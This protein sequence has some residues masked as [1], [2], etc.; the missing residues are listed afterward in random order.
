VTILGESTAWPA[1]RRTRS[2]ALLL[3]LGGV[4]M[5]PTAYAGDDPP[6]QFPLSIDGSAF[7]N[8]GTAV[9]IDGDTAV[10]T[11]PL[12]NVDGNDGYG[13]A[14]VYLRDGA[15]WIQQARLSAGDP[16]AFSNYGRS[17]AIDGDTI[18][19]GASSADGVTDAAGAVY[20]Y[21]RSGA[22]WT[23]QAK[24]VADDGEGFSDF[25]IAVDVDGDSIV[26]GSPSLF[27]GG[28]N[29][30]GAAYVYVRNA[31]LWTQ[32]QKLVASDG[33]AFASFGNAVAID[34]D[35]VAVAAHQ[36]SVGAASFSGAVYAF[37]RSGAVWSQTQKLSP[38]DA[39]SEDAF[40]GSLAMHG[41][42]LIV[43]ARQPALGGEGGAGV[44]YVF[45]QSGG[46][47]TQQ[48]RLAADNGAQGDE[49]GTA[50]AIEGDR[51]VVSAP[52][53]GAVA[54]V[55]REVGTL[56][57]YARVATDWSQ[58]AR[59]RAAAGRQGDH[60]AARLGLSAGTA[61]AGVPEARVG[62]DPAQGKA[63]LFALDTPQVSVTPAALD[64][65]DVA[66][67]S[68][69]SRVLTLRNLGTAHLFAGAALVTGA[70]AAQFSIVDDDCS[71][72]RVEPAASCAVEVA[73]APSALTAFSA[74]VI[75]PGSAGTTFVAVSGRGVPPAPQIAIAPSAMAETVPQNETISRAITIG[76]PGASQTL[77][78]NLSEDPGT[79]SGRVRVLGDATPIRTVQP[80]DRVARSGFRAAEG[81]RVVRPEGLPPVGRS[82]THSASDTIA[83]GN[84]IA[85]AD[86][87]TGFTNANQFLRT[88]TLSDFGID[89]SFAVTS[90]NVG[91]ERL[92]IAMPL[93]LNLYAL[94]GDLSYFNMQRLASTSVIL[95]PLQTS[96]VTLPI[97]LD[98]PPGT[99][100]VVEIA[101]PSL[102]AL[103]GVFIPGSNAAGQSAPSYAAAAACNADDPTDLADIGFPGMHL[104]MSVTGSSD[105]PPVDCALPAWLEVS[106]HA[107]AVVPGDVQPLS[108][109]FDATGLAIGEYTANLCVASNAQDSLV[110]VPVTLAVTAG[111]EL[112]APIFSDGF[113]VALH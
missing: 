39:A 57:V 7:E 15:N 40:G 95:Q 43:G 53:N 9:A 19:V 56:Y 38:A 66:V 35:E 108:V 16:E 22:N 11:T 23:Q 45:V 58:T 69:A 2:L 102:D 106:P 79:P 87:S 12:G 111:V 92:S 44:A 90:V 28:E 60:L 47:W 3:T 41:P 49:F 109:D 64:F 104:V 70:D 8:F 25:G 96:S 13:A 88:F 26:V 30:V 51:A 20:V 24:L 91:V 107:G 75:V 29:V 10:V 98:V 103:G 97:T 71:G 21:V 33:V 89:G 73:F 80:I 85:C 99:T 31:A 94:E 5:A 83:E 14:Y 93:T 54:G 112:P 67:D 86:N 61:I 1:L 6:A 77:H 52:F 68:A 59:I 46:G 105:A 18:A 100:L 72:Q 34:G 50:V 4:L 78:W 55:D 110:I 113:E 42:D 84:S 17:V 37:A 76:H 101:N 62:D 36:A 32:Q 82:L 65:G 81:G 74:Q 27:V 63:Y 48:A